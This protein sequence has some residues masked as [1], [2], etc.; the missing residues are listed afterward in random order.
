MSGRCGAESITRFDT[1]EC[2]S[3]SA[4]LVREFD[5]SAFIPPLKLR[6]VDAVGRLA[7]AGVR[8]L[9]EDAGRAVSASGHDDFGVALGTSTAGLDSLVEYLTGLTDHGP[10]GVPAILFSNTVSNAPASLCALE[11]GLRGPN[12]TFN[13]REASSSSA[14]AFSVGAIRQGRAAAMISGGVEC[15]EETF[16]KVLDRFRALSPMRGYQGS[17]GTEAARPFDRARNGFVLGEGGFLVLIESASAAAS[18]GARVYGEILGIG[19]SASSTAINAWPTDPAGLV[20]AMRL[21]LA[22]ANVRVE[23]IAAIVATS[24]GSPSLDRREAE[25]IAAVFGARS[26]PVASVKGAIGESGAAAAGGLIAGLLSIATGALVPTV[27]LLEADP[28]LPLRISRAAQPVAGS[29]FLVNSVASGGTHYCLV[30]RSAPQ[31]T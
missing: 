22:D 14:L 30:V 15:I 29:V 18:R 24:N 13:Q 5:P 9:F 31:P 1:S 27:G 25:A 4:A 26:V 2:H 6:R 17:D 10:T 7:L 16:F 11:Y 3:H 23:E 19:A 8:L 12:V 21:A 28:G 20:R